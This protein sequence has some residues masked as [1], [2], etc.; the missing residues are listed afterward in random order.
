MSIL[1]KIA[2]TAWVLTMVSM[3]FGLATIYSDKYQ[4]LAKILSISFGSILLL[5]GLIAIWS[6]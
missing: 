2:I 1:E 3:I 4:K 6:L 5:T